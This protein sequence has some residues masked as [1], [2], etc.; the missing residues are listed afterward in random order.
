MVEVVPRVDD[1]FDALS[2]WHAP[3]VSKWLAPPP[4]P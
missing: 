2:R 4:A 1:V 3:P